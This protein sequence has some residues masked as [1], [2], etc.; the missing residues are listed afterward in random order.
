MLDKKAE[1]EP[2]KML[3]GAIMA[4]LI[5][6]IIISA[7]NFFYSW[8]VNVSTERF[9]AGLKNAVEQPNGKPLVM[10][11]L[12]FDA[13]SVFSSSAL[14]RQIGLQGIDC[15]D[16]EGPSNSTAIIAS[17]DKKTISINNNLEINARAV[18]Y[19]NTSFECTSSCE[20]CCEIGFN[21]NS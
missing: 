18:C 9:Y 6:T 2:F 13:G 20:V 17:A 11:G 4:L 12:L 15:L 19:T 10:N 21:A 1:F 7:I 3:I 14:S 8:R 16:L 5:L